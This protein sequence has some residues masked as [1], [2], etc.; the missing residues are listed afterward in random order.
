MPNRHRGHTATS[1]DP[2]G[3][4]GRYKKDDICGDMVFTER[5]SHGCENHK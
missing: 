2:P 4:V 3:A 1:F 5:D